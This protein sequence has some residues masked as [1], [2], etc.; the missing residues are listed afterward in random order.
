MRGGRG[1]ARGG[2]TRARG[3][4]ANQRDYAAETGQELGLMSIFAHVAQEKPQPLFPPARIRQYQR[5]SWAPAADAGAGAEESA[6]AGASSSS[7]SS[8][9]AAPSFSSSAASSSFG[10]PGLHTTSAGDEH[11]AW[12]ASRAADM[13][14][15]VRA[16]PF[17]L[18]APGSA[19]RLFEHL[20]VVLHT[21]ALPREL[22]VRPSAAQVAASRKRARDAARELP[23]HVPR[24]RERQNSITEDLDT[25]EQRER[26]ARDGEVE[27]E[28][29]AGAGAGAVEGVRRRGDD[30]VVGDE[31][32]EDELQ[33][34]DEEDYNDYAE[35]HDDGDMGDDDDDDGGGD[36]DY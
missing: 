28:G 30:D 22:V 32:D 26:A 23:G 9:A 27:G 15:A 1:G 3:Y 17:N 36:G 33:D 18:D 24:G 35:L 5:P 12:M 25:L 19:K 31:G 2:A 34:E 13:R 8:S 4:V 29:G 7:S 10:A 20:D 14:E 11:V 16:S 6:G 21:T